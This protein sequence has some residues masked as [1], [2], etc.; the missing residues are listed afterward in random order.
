MPDYSKGKIYRIVCN[1]TGEQYIGST[2]QSLSRRLAKHVWES[3]NNQEH[4]CKSFPIIQRGNYQMV[5][6]EEYPCENKNQLDRRERHFIEATDCLNKYIP[7]RTKAEWHEAN[8]DRMLELQHQYRVENR[9]KIAE[10]HR[11]YREAN[12]DKIAERNRQYR[13]AN[14]AKIAEQKR[15]QYELHKKHISEYHKR[16]Y[17]AHREKIIKSA[18][19]NRAM[20]KAQHTPA[21]RALQDLSMNTL[22]AA[23]ESSPE[24]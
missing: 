9:D 2:I 13:E 14:P 7:S 23:L 12:R 11:Q 24:V 17:Q 6:V 19:Q 3:K 8:R 18:L 22:L 10:Q 4:G 20:K 1:E 16:Y 5:L 15:Q 21:Y